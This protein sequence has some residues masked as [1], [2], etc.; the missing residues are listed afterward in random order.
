MALAKNL[1]A[2]MRKRGYTNADLAMRFVTT[3]ATISRWRNGICN[4]PI[5]ILP[6]LSEFMGCSLDDLLR[7]PNPTPTPAESAAGQG[8]KTTSAT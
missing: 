6:E 3:C 5:D 1:D 7:E 2:L 4:P 8:L